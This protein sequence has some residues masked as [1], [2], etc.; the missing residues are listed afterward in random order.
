MFFFRLEYTDEMVKGEG[1][2]KMDREGL[3]KQ[4]LENQP[5]RNGNARQEL[6]KKKVHTITSVI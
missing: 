6:K 3:R 5:A 4:I 1:K 2:R